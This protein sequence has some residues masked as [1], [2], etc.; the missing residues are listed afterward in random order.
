MHPNYSDSSLFILNLFGQILDCVG[1]NLSLEF[2]VEEITLK[3]HVYKVSQGI[4]VPLVSLSKIHT[5]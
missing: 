1:Y 3:I 2:I 4:F 5:T